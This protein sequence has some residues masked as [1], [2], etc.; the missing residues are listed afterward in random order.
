LTHVIYCINPDCDHRQNPENLESCQACGTPLL[1]R[2]KYWL[3]H[4]LR[5][6]DPERSTE[7]FEVEVE[8]EHRVMKILKSSNPK[9]V[10]LFDQEAFTL[11]ILDHPG[12]P[13]I[14]LDG[15]FQLHLKTGKALHCLV[16]EKIEGENLE[17]WIEEHGKISQKI[18]RNWLEQ[19]IK[20]LDYIHAK[21][22]FHRDIKP[23]NIMIEPNG[24]LVIIDF[25]TVREINDTYMIAFRGSPQPNITTIVSRGYTAPEQINGRATPQSDLFALGR[26]FVHLL[27][28]LSPS[29]LPADS[30][31]G[32]LIWQKQAPQVNKLFADLIDDL[33]ARSPRDRPKDSE[34]VLKS[35]DNLRLRSI[36]RFITSP[37]FKI[38]AIALVSF[39]VLL[40]I[41]SFLVN[42]FFISPSRAKLYSEQGRKALKNDNFKLARQNFE[43]A[44]KLNPKESVFYNDLGLVCKLQKDY[45]C[46]QNNYQKSLD[47]L[48]DSDLKST[49]CK[50]QKCTEENYK[51]LLELASNSE[52]L[53]VTYYN[54]GGL[55]EGRQEYKLALDAYKIAMQDRGLAGI[56]AQN[57]YARLKIWKEHEHEVAIENLQEVLKKIKDLDVLE[58]DKIVLQASSFK[59]LGW[60]YLQQGNYQKAEQLLDKAINLD[61]EDRAGSYCLM[62]K[63][64]QAQEKNKKA[65]SA[66]EKCRDNDA[67]NLPEVITW[68]GDA[69]QYLNHRKKEQ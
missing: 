42:K 46:A 17:Q 20:I 66:W 48:S 39:G 44:I 16:M 19:L 27:T 8:G 55:Y 56:Y 12:I 52:K 43:R 50:L 67:K 60:A 30:K 26:T 1:V 5:P 7:I 13:K 28:G 4:P 69:N 3:L 45:E 31:T 49:L 21:G 35:L 47:F 14:D 10:E 33:M 68:Q 22:F 38:I 18:A 40:G 15:F 9:L 41:T 11:E 24:Q 63:T 32:N 51:A 29:E 57:N 2:E 58:E 53:A 61:E 62:A 37:R 23:S 36:E 59:N 54:L 64:L 65:K 25:G 6:L 34:A